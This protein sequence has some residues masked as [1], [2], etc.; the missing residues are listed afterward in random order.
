[1][2]DLA[3]LN[4]YDPQALGNVALAAI[5]ALAQ[6]KGRSTNYLTPLAAMPEAEDARQALKAAIEAG[7][8]K[9]HLRN[10]M[11]AAFGMDLAGQANATIGEAALFPAMEPEMAQASLIPDHEEGLERALAKAIQIA[12]TPRAVEKAQ[13]GAYTRTHNGKVIQVHEY[14]TRRQ[15]SMNATKAAHASSDEALKSR[16]PEDHQ[17]ASAAHLEALRQHTEAHELSPADVAQDHKEL[18][19]H[20]R[21]AARWHSD[22]AKGATAAYG[23]EKVEAHRGAAKSW[24]EGRREELKAGKIKGAFAGPH[25]SFPI[26]GPEDVTH[27]WDLAGHAEN[28]QEIRE[29]IRRIAKDHGWQHALP[30]SAKPNA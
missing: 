19:D 2:S 20:H 4:P 30:G 5:T 3:T 25:E 14:Q 9:E 6:A 23:T 18:M 1:M 22:K 7:C 26:A 13:V 8:P 10:L 15:G 16:K 24:D 12:T 11:K 29:N 27:A 17:K 21:A 28:P